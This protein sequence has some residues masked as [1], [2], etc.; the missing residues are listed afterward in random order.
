MVTRSYRGDMGVLTTM[1]AKELVI[2]PVLQDALGLTVRL[3]EGVDTDAFGTFSRER[4]RT[5]SQ[6]DAARAKVLAGFERVPGAR[7]G[8]ASEGSFGPHPGI[9]LVAL[10]REL[11]LMIDRE[12][13]LE[14][15][16]YDASFETNF[17]HVVVTD[18]GAGLS[19]AGHAGFP[20]HGLIVMGNHNGLPAP[21]TYLNKNIADL[22]A[23]E[24]AIRRAIGLCGAAFVET[25]MRANR[26]PTRM[27]A[28]ARATR[29]LVRRLHRLC[30]SCGHPGFDV[31][32]RIS[33]LPCMWCGR[34]T[35]V[36]MTDI[37]GCGS[38]GH[39]EERP[40]AA[41]ARADPGR[42]DHCNP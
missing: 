2:A 22:P 39:R 19:F 26:N 28:I 3:A 15:V 13:G 29:D 6:L 41:T 40:A 18:V 36:V 7:V 11:V 5:G 25:D 35:A 37:L 27:V 12:S 10:G 33:G 38:C 17:A 21:R 4:E 24:S 20:A 9:P 30:P 34:P 32:Q 31:T 14:L 16:G 8:F 1:H 23:L 42:C